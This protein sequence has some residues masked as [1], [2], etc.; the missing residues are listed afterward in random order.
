MYYIKDIFRDYL[1]DDNICSDISL[2]WILQNEIKMQIGV[3]YN[4][5]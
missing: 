3:V 1:F 4:T 5:D 2:Q